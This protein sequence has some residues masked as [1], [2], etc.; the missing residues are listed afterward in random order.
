MSDSIDIAYKNTVGNNK[1]VCIT[2][3]HFL[4]IFKKRLQTMVLIFN[5]LYGNR[6]P[7]KCPYIRHVLKTW[8]NVLIE[9]FQCNRIQMKLVHELGFYCLHVLTT[10]IYCLILIDPLIYNIYCSIFCLFTFFVCFASYYSFQ[11]MASLLFENGS[12]L[13]FTICLNGLIPNSVCTLH[14]C[15]HNVS[16]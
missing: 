14:K 4:W 15:S 7:V 16:S 12:F 10:S 13:I 11:W 1:Y 9:R 2:N 8:C 3:I 6:F 5:M